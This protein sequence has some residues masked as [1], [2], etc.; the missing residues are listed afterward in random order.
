M[1]DLQ[2][3]VDSVPGVGPARARVLAAAG[4]HTVGD[5][6]LQLPL[7]YEDRSR[8]LPV[9]RLR[10]GEPACVCVRVLS[11]RRTGPP[12]RRA[13][14][15]A[16][17]EDDSGRLAAVWFNQPYVRDSL[18]PGTRVL[19]YGRPVSYRGR[20][21]LV[22]PVHAAADAAGES[23]HLGRPVPVY[24]RIGPLGAGV[25][26]RLIHA[27]LE[28]LADRPVPLDRLL[29]GEGLPTRTA[30]LRA[31][32]RPETA[33]EL[34]ALS[35]RTSPA[36]RRLALEEFVDYQVA[37]GLLARQTRTERGRALAIED[38][39]LERLTAPLPFRLTGAQR[40]C[41]SELLEGMR[42][43]APMHRL[44]QGDVG[45]GKTAVAGCALL[46][47][48]R[49]GVQAALLAPTE[50]LAEQHLRTLAPWAGALGV[51][52][53][54]LTAAVQ[55]GERRALLERLASGQLPIV[56]G[57][58][59][60]L[61]PGVHF[62]RLGLV[63]VDEQHRF[64]VAQRAALRAK[65][66]GVVPDL[67][68]TTATPI[69]RSLALTLY[70]DLEV[71]RLDELP[72]GRAPVAT[73]IVP[74]E[75]WQEVRERLVAA[76]RNGERAFLVAPT[77]EDGGAEEPLR[78]VEALADQLRRLLPREAVALL[79][80]GQERAE[81]L[82][83]MA[84]FRSGCARLLVATTVVEVGVDV[85]DATLI[86]IDHAERFGLAQLH[87]LRG[88]VGRG[89]RPG[90]CWLVA[91]PPLSESAR[92]RLR[93]LV[94]Q[95]D[96][97]LIAEQ[98]LRLRGPGELLG[99]RQAGLPELRTADPFAHVEWLLQARA[100]ARRI[101]AGADADAIAY[102]SAVQERWRRRIRMARAG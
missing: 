90:S 16:E 33:A 35:A 6:L 68:V 100:L 30:A 83:A 97:F 84:A 18:R 24:R 65:G 48:A 54:L 80:G 98:D 21:Q 74:A 43:P 92:R 51:Q 41:V 63:V 29:A 66:G 2:D 85:P 1:L 79:H 46:A 45:S 73:R 40:R 13:R 101:L 72:A 87:Q 75:R 34:A 102:R 60:L 82:R 26:R 11:C 38:D 28:Q 62:R 96:G 93:A 95:H 12:G 58:H 7:R 53:G 27:L 9:A 47:A 71:T 59:A 86:V 15:L 17:L 81:Q 19:L 36:Y 31:I 61:Q 14:V 67:L 76:A 78:G 94:Q 23:L 5:L 52:V 89:S 10:A 57:T 88:R 39:A 44:L 22:N 3:P 20:L 64:G 49:A 25:L 91:H 32:H 77:I 56:I 8:L 37:L 50:I 70:G 55:A 4:V 69:P 99:V 42:S